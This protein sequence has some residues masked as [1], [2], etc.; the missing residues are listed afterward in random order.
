MPSM[1]L[2]SRT[3]HGILSGRQGP[4]VGAVILTGAGRGFNSGGDMKDM[5]RGLVLIAWGPW[6]LLTPGPDG[7]PTICLGWSNL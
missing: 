4:E 6:G 7:W 2:C 1:K 3:W 5:A